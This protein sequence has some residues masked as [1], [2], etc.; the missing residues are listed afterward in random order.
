MIPP[1]IEIIPKTSPA[2]AQPFPLYIPGFLLNLFKLITLNT[3][4]AVPNKK[5]TR[6]NP[7]N[8]EKKL[9]NPNASNFLFVG[10]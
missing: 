9:T 3:T 4:A 8:P 7:T 1:M 6:N 5:G 10:V 2:I